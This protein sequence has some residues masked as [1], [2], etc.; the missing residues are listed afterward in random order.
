[1]STE[2]YKARSTDRSTSPWKDDRDPGQAYLS[3]EAWAYSIGHDPRGQQVVSN[4][5]REF[6]ADRDSYDH[7]IG[8]S[9]AATFFKP[10]DLDERWKQTKF[11]RLK[12]WNDGTRDADR[13]IVEGEKD[14]VE[15]TES[16]GSRLELPRHVIGEAKDLIDDLGNISRLGYYNNL[17]TAVLSALTEAYRRE[18]LRRRYRE[19]FHDDREMWRERDDF[20]RLW[21][22][23]GLNEDEL[24]DAITLL[25]KKTDV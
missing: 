13:Q 23:L 20:R 15:W 21:E 7:F 8:K 16:Y 25:K 5:N 19:G 9:S 18:W 4:K 12:G 14:K 6:R 24:C 10:T 22:S 1:M 3:E 17:H 2:R 11:E